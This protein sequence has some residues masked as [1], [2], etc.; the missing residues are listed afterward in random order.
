MPRYQCRFFNET[1]EVVR[2][3]VLGA[4]DDR[5]AH[6]EART[7][8]AKTGHFSG[9]ELLE[10]GRRVDVYRPIQTLSKR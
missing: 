4:S 10:D 5:D 3:E 6:R 8:M 2:I 7:L 1:E 9:Y